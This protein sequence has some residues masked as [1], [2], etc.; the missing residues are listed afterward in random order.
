MTDIERLEHRRLELQAKLDGTKSHLERNQL[1]Q[2]ATPPALATEILSYGLTLLGQES[3]IH[4]L[5]PA[6]GT[7]SFFS[8]LLRCADRHRIESSV[9]F[10]IDAHY[11]QPTA[12]LWRDTPLQL[13]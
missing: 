4:F 7:G 5:D 8:A 3:T 6:I 13:H 1:G 10:E 12:E 9:G 11:G 2:F